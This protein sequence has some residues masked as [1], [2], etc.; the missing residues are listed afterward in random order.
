MGERISLYADQ[1]KGIDELYDEVKDFDLVLTVDAPLADALNIRLDRAKLGFFATTARRWAI[2]QCRDKVLDKR[3]LYLKAVKELGIDWK[4]TAFLLDNIIDC[5]INTGDISKIL[6]YRKFRREGTNRILELISSTSNFFNILERCTP[7]QGMD[8]AVVGKYQFNELDKKVLPQRYTDVS[9]FT[10]SKQGLTPF[11]IFNSDTEMIKTIQENVLKYNPN[12]VALVLSDK[13]P[14]DN[15]ILSSFDSNDIPYMADIP[16][17]EHPGLRYLIYLMSMGLS[18]RGIKVKD[19]RPLMEP[20]NIN[21]SSEYDEQYI[22]RSGDA[23]INMIEK[24]FTKV[25]TSSFGELL[26]LCK[27]ELDMDIDPVKEHIHELEIRDQKITE[28]NLNAL[29]YYLNTFDVSLDSSAHGVLLASPK[30]SAYIDR[31]MVF[32]MGMESTWTP[33]IGRKPWIDPIKCD[34]LMKKNFEVLL[35]NGES[36]YYMVKSGDT[37]PCFYFNEMVDHSIESFSDFKH[38]KHGYPFEE[39]MKPF[40]APKALIGSKSIKGISQSSLNLFVHSPKDYMFSKMVRSPAMW[41]QLRGQLLHDFAEFYIAHPEFCMSQPIDRFLEV[42]LEEIK[43][44]IDELELKVFATQMKEGMKNL[45]MYLDSIEAP[46]CVPEGYG[47]ASWST[48]LFSEAFQKP[49]GDSPTELFFNNEDIGARGVVD[50]MVSEGE[51]VDHKSGKKKA[52]SKIMR[53]TKP[54]QI[55]G[56]PNLQPLMYLAHHRFLYPDTD[57]VFTFNHPLENVDKR[58]YDRGDL[59]DNLVQIDYYAAYFDDIVVTRGVFDKLFNEAG[60]TTNRRKVLERIGYGNYAD[61][62]EDRK[63]TK[64]YLQSEELESEFTD[65]V[66]EIL[67]DHKYVA[68]GSRGILKK[69]LELREYCLFKEDLDD[70]ERYLNNQLTLLNHYMEKGFPVGDP[71]PDKL[72]NKDMVIL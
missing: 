52:L 62:F 67:G 12:D 55:G 27:E 36:Q 70:F 47:K 34:Q 24:L 54:D 7:P 66:K 8:L 43:P 42:L 13:D 51:I 20:L 57:I 16:I 35:Q 10:G 25:R 22:A 32:Y 58:I 37:T 40:V 71:D 18:T 64:E 26:D 30:T 61:F 15:L 44:Y 21:I 4:E 63:F 41:Y 6:D 33:D 49:V 65:Y 2:D 50:L 60:T 69:L 38:T 72:E 9:L 45:M 48:N 29:I 5:W 39:K 23:G 17:R 59:Y 31:P 3:Q 68:R 1:S 53:E 56:K 28:E 46:K 14:Y 19:V 11:R